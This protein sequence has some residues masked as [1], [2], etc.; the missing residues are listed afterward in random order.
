ML[1]GGKEPSTRTTPLHLLDTNLV[2]AIA[3]SEWLKVRHLIIWTFSALPP[4]GFIIKNSSQV[5]STAAL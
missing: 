5:I 4:F 2:V 1:L 3:E